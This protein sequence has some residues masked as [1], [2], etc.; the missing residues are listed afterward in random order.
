[1]T[2][3][4]A[5]TTPRISLKEEE[6]RSDQ[7]LSV[8]IQQL[9]V[10]QQDRALTPIIQFFVYMNV[11]LLVS[12]FVFGM[13]EHFTPTQAPVITDK[14]FIASVGAVA[15]QSGAIIIAAFRGL[16]SKPSDKIR[17]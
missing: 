13:I 8:A 4:P 15:I 11:V 2:K 9:I 6:L 5:K 17:R 12:V 14:V 3:I 1:M 10:D 16:F 7:Q